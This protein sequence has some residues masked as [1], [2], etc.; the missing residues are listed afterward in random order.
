MLATAMNL[1]ELLRAARKGDL[2]AFNRLV[3]EHQDQAY[4]LAYYLLGDE[5]RAAAAIQAAVLRAYAAL[6]SFHKGTF[7][8]WLLRWV[9]AACDGQPTLP[10]SAP[11][12]PEPASMEAGLRRKLLSLPPDWRELAILVD[13]LG[14]D[15]EEAA[16]VSGCTPKA[17]SHRL[18]RARGALGSKGEI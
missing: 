7:R 15:Y 3:L 12:A 11:P 4:T 17:M 13:L 2:M 18:A 9:L 14:L 8:G 5:Q 10:A 1:T 6:G 16:Q